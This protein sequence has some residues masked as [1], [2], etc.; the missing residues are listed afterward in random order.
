MFARFAGSHSRMPLIPHPILTVVD[1]QSSRSII[2]SY[3]NLDFPCSFSSML[4]GSFILMRTV[5]LPLYPGVNRCN[6]AGLKPSAFIKILISAS[7]GAIEPLNGS[8]SLVRMSTVKQT[9]MGPSFT[10]HAAVDVVD[11]VDK[12]EFVRGQRDAPPAYVP[13]PWL[14]VA[15]P[16]LP[17]DCWGPWGG[18]GGTCIIPTFFWLL[19]LDR[20]CGRSFLV[21]HVGLVCSSSHKNTHLFL[22]H[23]K[24]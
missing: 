10:F 13:P 12:I 6:S 19:Q 20:A 3:L 11:T 21:I 16:L 7:F 14:G 9:L 17:T 18:W 24:T 2:F 22:T 23:A 15:Q 4:N 1:E 8:P 5:G